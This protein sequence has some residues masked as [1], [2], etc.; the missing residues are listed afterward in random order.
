M[1]SFSAMKRRVSALLKRSRCYSKILAVKRRGG[2]RAIRAEKEREKEEP[3][4]IASPPLSFSIHGIWYQYA[5][6]DSATSRAHPSTYCGLAPS[7]VAHSTPSYSSL[8]IPP[9][10]P[11]HISPVLVH[12]RRAYTSALR[13]KPL[14]CFHHKSRYSR[15]IYTSG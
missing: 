7:T 15:R 5:R 9:S 12:A 2:G 14:N 11:E 1:D 13:P 6:Y 10:H 3:A 4:A 8:R